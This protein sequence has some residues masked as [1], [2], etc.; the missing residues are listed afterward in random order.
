MKKLALITLLAATPALAEQT[1]PET[2]P[3]QKIVLSDEAKSQLAEHVMRIL[4]EHSEM[5]AE[6]KKAELRQKTKHM[7]IGCACMA[8]VSW[9][10]D[11]NV[12]QH[13]LVQAAYIL[14]GHGKTVRDLIF[15]IKGKA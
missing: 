6:Y 12:V 13:V 8:G 15:G 9:A 11:C 4:L 3:G 7:L 1:A 2:T 10:F 5:I 14:L